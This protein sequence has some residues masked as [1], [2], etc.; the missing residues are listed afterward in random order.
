MAVQ[1]GEG[2]A[3]GEGWYEEGISDISSLLLNCRLEGKCLGCLNHFG[4]DDIFTS[5]T[6]SLTVS[7]SVVE[8]GDMF[9]SLSQ[10]FLLRS[11]GMST[12]APP[13][14]PSVVGVSQLLLSDSTLRELELLQFFAFRRLARTPS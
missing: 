2:T 12:E 3:K 6:L 8:L 9:L 4:L 13:E 11:R 14:P 1:F 7:K 5:P 10:D